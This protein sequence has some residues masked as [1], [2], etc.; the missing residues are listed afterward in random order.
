[1]AARQSAR[2]AGC[3]GV[4]RPGW[5]RWAACGRSAAPAA[6]AG[7]PP[8]GRAVRRPQRPG[9]DSHATGRAGL[10][11]VPRAGRRASRVWGS[12][13]SFC[14]QK[15]LQPRAAATSRCSAVR[16]LLSSRPSPRPCGR[17]VPA[18][19]VSGP[20]L[21]PGRPATPKAVPSRLTRIPARQHWVWP[22]LL[23]AEG[24]CAEVPAACACGWRG[25]CAVQ[26]TADAWGPAP[27]PRYSYSAANSLPRAF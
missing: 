25:G 4:G 14:F 24:E 5:A 16:S 20:G 10:P 22:W 1:M 2:S 17:P 11:H 27:R 6:V 7:E 18:A 23:P 3:P 19:L 26:W 13:T 15:A 8:R 12:G 9:P 21:A